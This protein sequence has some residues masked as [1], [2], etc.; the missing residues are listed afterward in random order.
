MFK[1]RKCVFKRKIEQY[2]SRFT[3]KVIVAFT[4]AVRC[5]IFFFDISLISFA[6]KLKLRY[7]VTLKE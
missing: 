7:S 1:K 3:V 6:E 5:A 4:P 2:F